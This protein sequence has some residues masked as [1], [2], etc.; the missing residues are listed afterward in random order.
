M[1]SP[2]KSN[3]SNFT[4]DESRRSE[5]P[6][7]LHFSDVDESSPI[8]N[9]NLEST[10][11]QPD[12]E[13]SSRRNSR[14]MP[15]AQG[16][17]SLKV[18]SHSYRGLIPDG[19]RQDKE[20]SIMPTRFMTMYKRR[21]KLA[22]IKNTVHIF[23]STAERK[24][25]KAKAIETV[26]CLFPLTTTRCF[27]ALK[28]TN[29]DV[30]KG[31]GDS[32]SVDKHV[33]IIDTRLAG[34]GAGQ[35]SRIYSEGMPICTEN[36]MKGPSFCSWITLSQQF[37]ADDDPV[38]RFKPYFGDNDQDDVV[39]ANFKLKTKQEWLK[40]RK[41]EL[42][43]ELDYF[44]LKEVISLLKAK[45]HGNFNRLATRQKD[46]LPR[47]LLMSI[48][49]SALKRCGIVTTKSISI[50]HGFPIKK[51]KS[52]KHDDNEVCGKSAINLIFDSYNVLFCRSCKV[53][54]CTT[55]NH[56]YESLEF[57]QKFALENEKRSSQ[58]AINVNP[59][60]RILGLK[61]D[62]LMQK[63]WPARYKVIAR[64]IISICRGNMCRAVNVVGHRDWDELTLFRKLQEYGMENLILQLQTTRKYENQRGRQ[65]KKIRRRKI[66]NTLYSEMKRNNNDVANRF[67]PC[68]HDGIC[69]KKSC[70][71]SRNGH[72][73]LKQCMLFTFSRSMATI[74]RILYSYIYI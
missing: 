51:R 23:N 42:E 17:V 37:F 25:I 10:T 29:H 6:R 9:K 34:K 69:A 68:A 61:V 4:D 7:M 66:S 16:F 3:A 8:L 54:D 44:V 46:S 53:Y 48:K 33:R 58:K 12:L 45:A 65:K 27:E 40:E 5:S 35:T 56:S 30:P 43:E 2:I 20:V 62:A 15:A 41:V 24:R 72:F 52:N 19:I 14:L 47:I 67:L 13:A 28:Q 21:C 49:R 55:H 59:A 50:V 71:C 39:S 70:L 22:L 1:L 31:L 63:A 36:M 11:S 57:W 73:C 38:L 32:K 60:N 26:G 18:L 74:W 64:K